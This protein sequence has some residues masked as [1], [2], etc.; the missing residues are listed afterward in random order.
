[1]TLDGFCDHTAV[2][3]DDGLHE[4]YN[5]VLKSAGALIY[6]RV[7]YQLMESYWPDVARN[8]TGNKAGD[9]FAVLIDNLPKLVFSRTL[10]S[11]EWKSAT[12]ARKDVKEE[13]LQL[14]QQPGKD[15]FVGSP[16]L[17]VTCAN[18][19]LIDEYQLCVHPVIA[20]TGLPLFNN[21]SGRSVLKLLNTKTLPGGQVVLSYERG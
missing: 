6:G 12:L 11:V 3:A 21:I 17:I 9:E 10:N 5:D 2:I 18:L 20:G 16:G 1:M 4:Y 14:L 19:N 13:V 8:P 7:T 15:V